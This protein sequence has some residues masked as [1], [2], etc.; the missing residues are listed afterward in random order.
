MA[1]D[2]YAGPLCR[3][4][5][6]DFTSPLEKVFGPGKVTTLGVRGQSLGKA[7]PREFMMPVSAWR[8]KIEPLLGPQKTGTAVGAAAQWLESASGPVW[9]EQL[10]QSGLDALR[11]HAAYLAIPELTRPDQMPENMLADPAWHVAVEDPENSAYPALFFCDLWLPL[12]FNGPVAVPAFPNRVG[13]TVILAATRHVMS[14]LLDINQK[15]WKLNHREPQSWEGA[16]S[17]FQVPLDNWALN[18]W[19]LLMAA[20]IHSITHNV[21]VVLDG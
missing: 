5:A 16:S 8:R 20:L 3:Y 18:A 19:Q 14:E 17:A 10:T 9:C 11:L 13:D 2:L 6:R 15:S 7:N 12:A 21:P 1:L 4:L